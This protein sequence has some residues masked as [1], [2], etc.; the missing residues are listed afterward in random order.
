MTFRTT[1]RRWS[2]RIRDRNRRR[3]R[4]LGGLEDDFDG[5]E[6]DSEDDERRQR[7]EAEHPRIQGPAAA[8]AIAALKQRRK[9]LKGK[10]IKAQVRAEAIGA[11]QKRTRASRA[12]DG[13]LE[14]ARHLCITMPRTRPRRS[15]APPTRRSSAGA[16]SAVPPADGRRLRRSSGAQP[17]RAGTCVNKIFFL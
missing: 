12:K 15:C 1:F 4:R 5:D 2:Q 13:E 10:M 14:L 9:D 8:A 11:A 7:G 16:Q 6:F 3:R 17:G